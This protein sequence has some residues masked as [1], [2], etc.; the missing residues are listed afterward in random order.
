LRKALVKLPVVDKQDI[1]FNRLSVGGE[2]FNKR[3]LAIAQ[4]NHGFVWL[5]TDDGLYRYDGYSLRAYQHDPNNPTQF[6]RQ[7]RD[8][9][10]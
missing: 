5:G 8:D 6:E 9:D 7:H 10:R 1:R 2:P 3:V 4:D